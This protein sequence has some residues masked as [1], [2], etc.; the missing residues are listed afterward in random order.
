MSENLL[1]KLTKTAQ[2]DTHALTELFRGKPKQVL[3][4]ARE[5]KTLHLSLFFGAIIATIVFANYE[6][7]DGAALAREAPGATH[8]V[9][10]VKEDSSKDQ[11]IIRGFGN[12][13]IPLSVIEKHKDRF[14]I[15]SNFGDFRFSRIGFDG[16]TSIIGT[17]I[18]DTTLN[19]G[20]LSQ[21][22]YDKLNSLGLE[23]IFWGF[24]N[25]HNFEHLIDY[26]ASLETALKVDNRPDGATLKRNIQSGKEVT[27]RNFDPENL[28][29]LVTGRVE[30]SFDRV[31]SKAEIINLSSPLTI[32]NLDGG[33]VING[34]STK[35]GTVNGKVITN[36][37][38]NLRG[39]KALTIDKQAGGWIIWQMGDEPQMPAGLQAFLNSKQDELKKLIEGENNTILNSVNGQTSKP[40]LT[41][42]QSPKVSDEKPESTLPE[43]EN[44][45]HNNLNQLSSN[46]SFLLPSLWKISSNN[47]PFVENSS[48]IFKGLELT[49]VNTFN[50]LVSFPQ[51]LGKL[52][53]VGLVGTTE[54]Q[55]EREKSEAAH[56]AVS[57][58]E[59]L[60]GSAAGCVLGA[61]AEG[62]ITD[63]LGSIQGCA[64]GST[65]AG[66]AIAMFNQHEKDLPDTMRAAL[67]GDKDSSLAQIFG[68]QLGQLLSNGLGAKVAHEAVSNKILQATNPIDDAERVGQ[69]LKENTSTIDT[70]AQESIDVE[71]AKTC[72]FKINGKES[73]AERKQEI[74]KQGG[75]FTIEN[76]D[77]NGKILNIRRDFR[78]ENATSGLSKLVDIFAENNVKLD[79]EDLSIALSKQ[80]KNL[81]LINGYKLKEKTRSQVEG[82]KESENCINYYLINGKYVIGEITFHPEGH[83]SE[84][85]K[86]DTNATFPHYNYKINNID[87]HVYY[88]LSK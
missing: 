49:T 35:I 3:E 69:N 18:E 13:D 45:I 37:T 86:N 71:G 26:V 46:Y 61:A 87:G 14:S 58:V 70:C 25:T 63:G 79:V 20:D 21:E 2:T 59:S 65:A 78:V 29:Y 34:Y 17:K 82:N 40:E 72:G 39:D 27:E 11:E 1:T 12:I 47:N 53:G 55:K 33:T 76:F 62:L 30:Q 31:G 24:Y 42:S 44:V 88:P 43:S 22:A 48:E 85:M 23:K 68:Y 74:I 64:L 6:Y 54:A 15:C 4:L 80:E 51:V 28:T 32:G 50:G 52:A 7:G 38:N 66:D 77:K 56:L 8:K 16:C 81:D 84:Y 57:G 67:G 75:E 60:V 19:G 10:L 73:T 41:P 36:Y 9:E 5:R 83:S